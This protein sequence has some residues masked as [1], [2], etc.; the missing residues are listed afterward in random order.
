MNTESDM[1]PKKRYVMKMDRPVAPESIS[2][3]TV[4]EARVYGFL[5]WHAASWNKVSLTDLSSILGP[6]K[7]PIGLV[8]A[9]QIVGDLSDQGLVQIP[10]WRTNPPTTPLRVVVPRMPVVGDPDAHESPTGVP[11]GQGFVT[12]AGMPEDLVAELVELHRL[13]GEHAGQPVRDVRWMEREVELVGRRLRAFRRWA[14]MDGTHKLLR[15]VDKLIRV[16][17]DVKRQLVGLRSKQEAAES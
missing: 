17:Q 8:R 16:E 3:L 7:V 2:R 9:R 13:F 10:G 14:E 6:T 4:D 11:V 12:H 5:A 1:K 15:M